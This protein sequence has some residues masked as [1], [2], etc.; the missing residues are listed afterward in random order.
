[1]NIKRIEYV[2]EFLTEQMNHWMLFPLALTVMGISRELTGMSSPD[3]PVWVLCGI[4]PLAFFVLR[5]KF[6]RFYLFALLHIGAVGGVVLAASAAGASL[7]GGICVVSA[8]VYALHS[9]LLQLKKDVLYS[10]P[11][12]LPVGVVISVMCLLLQHYQ[13]TDEWDA[14]YSLALIGAIALFFVIFYL[15][16]Y[17]DFLSVNKSSAGYLPA[18][19]MF[20]SGLGLALGYTLLGTVL[21]AAFTH[22]KGFS[23]FVQYVKELL[24]RFLRFLFSMLPG[25]G[26]EELMPVPEEIGGPPMDE[27]F[28]REEPFWLWE[29]LWQIVMLAAVAGILFVAVK[30]LIRLIKWLQEFLVLRRPR[31]NIQEEEAFDIRERCEIEKT[32]ERKKQNPFGAF[33]CRERIRKLYKKKLL[34]ASVQMPERERNRLGYDTAREWE[35]KLDAGGMAE[36]YERARY[37]EREVTG[38]DVKKMKEACRS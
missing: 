13:G 1:M 31:E 27:V 24:L 15:Q 23:D 29:V 35:R 33:S 2:K 25:G 18:S 16:R 36:I 3:L 6:R 12:Q 19:E 11:I 14:Y 17:L 30:M 26:Q 38:A 4:F 7:R 8:F 10:E 21:L 28:P 22:F 32:Q 34:S 20:R 9:I 37:S 5:C